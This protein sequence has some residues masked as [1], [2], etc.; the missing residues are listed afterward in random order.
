[1]DFEELMAPAQ[2]PKKKKDALRNLT[3]VLGQFL[4]IFCKVKLPNFAR[5]TTILRQSLSN[6]CV[7]RYS[8]KLGF[9][10]GRGISPIHILLPY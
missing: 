9:R 6:L 4:I 5:G 2:I 7:F 3:S 8:V 1:M 10:G